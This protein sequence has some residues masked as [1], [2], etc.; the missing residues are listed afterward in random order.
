MDYKHFMEKALEQAKKALSANEFPVGCVM[1]YQNK[2]ILTGSR[3]GTK[4]NC[5]NEVD[6]AEM[7]ALRRLSHM[8]D[9][10]DTSRITIFCT[11]EPCLMCFG[12][13]LLSG[14]GEIVYAY[15]DPM[16]G[17]TRCDLTQLTPLYKNSRISIIPNILRNES[18]E[19]FKAYFSNPKNKYWKGSILARYTLGQ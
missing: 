9:D 10:I 18:L 17:G 15:E 2:I 5:I 1:V 13:L 14:I 11:L 6:H 12:A 3:T 4:G 8:L 7:N 16:G 19:L